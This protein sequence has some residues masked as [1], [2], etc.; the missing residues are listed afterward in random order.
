V[1]PQWGLK[2]GLGADLTFFAFPASLTA[3]YGD[4]PVGLHAFLRVRWG[5][6]HA[7]GGHAGHGTP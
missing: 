1:R 4:S 3:A 5:R 7:H 2:A 6:P